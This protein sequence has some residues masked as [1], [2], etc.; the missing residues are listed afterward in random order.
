MKNKKYNLTINFQRLSLLLCLTIIN[1]SKQRLVSQTGVL[2]DSFQNIIV[3]HCIVW[4][5]FFIFWEDL[6][7]AKRFT[8]S[9][10]W[11]KSFLRGLEGAYKLLWFYI[12]DNCNHAGIW[13]I[14]FDVAQLRIGEDMII[15]QGKAEQLFKDK[16]IIFDNNK[17]WFIPCFVEFQYGQL[18][19]DNRA[20][21][22]VIIILKK[23][24]LFKGL[25]RSLQAHKD[26]DK[27]KDKE[28][29]KDKDK[30]KKKFLDFVLLTTKEY[31]KLI[32]TLG[33]ESTDDFINRLNDYIGSKGK[34]YKSHYYTILTWSRKEPGE[35]KQGQ[36]KTD[37]DY[38]QEYEIT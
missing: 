22:S 16:I 33:R 31:E 18:S 28:L 20:H 1:S 7:M 29:D 19:Q 2:R 14:E 5:A 23:Y 13:D 37:E 32:E 11:K 36:V 9:E 21:K 34:K 26:K 12:L 24:K 17:K 3:K 8:D 6:P 15:E 27:D 30:E 38:K 4:L 35:K 25:R 10:K